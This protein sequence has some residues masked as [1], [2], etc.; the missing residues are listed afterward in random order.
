MIKC[1]VKHDK[2]ERE[3]PSNDVNMYNMRWNKRNQSEF[4]REW[5][6]ERQWFNEQKRGPISQFDELKN[7]KKAEKRM[8]K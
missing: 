8:W 4:S 1:E 3:T 2:K 5:K 7:R 6:R